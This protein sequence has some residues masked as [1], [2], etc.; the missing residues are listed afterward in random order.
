MGML[1]GKKGSGPSTL[2]T[3]MEGIMAEAWYRSVGSSGTGSAFKDERCV[4]NKFGCVRRRLIEG[5]PPP[6]PIDRLDKGVHPGW[7]SGAC[8]NTLDVSPLPRSG[9]AAPMAL[10]LIHI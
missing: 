8:P 2:L 4:R 9:T 3:G 10:S 7:K 6:W 1:E 5:V